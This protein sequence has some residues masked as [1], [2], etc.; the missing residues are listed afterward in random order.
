MPEKSTVPVLLI[1][2][3]SDDDYYL[4]CAAL[5]RCR[6]RHRL[7]RVRDGI[8]LMDY[9]RR[10]GAHADPQASPRPALILL[11]LNMP[12]KDG[13]ET[14]QEI[15]TDPCLRRIPVVVFT[16]S[17]H[18]ESVQ[19]GYELGCNAFIQKPIGLA[20]LALMMEAVSRL[21]L[22]LPVLPLD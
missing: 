20:P 18:V 6:V 22:L 14:L 9:L 21:F 10:R 19:R 7:V 16:S 12:L 5:E 1:A 4:A 11:D 8:E 3:D 13:F 15:K 17:G 2:E